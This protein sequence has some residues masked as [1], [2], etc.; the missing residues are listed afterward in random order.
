MDTR[1]GQLYPDKDAAM[2]AGVP[3]EFVR[4]VS[5]VTIASGPFAGRKY[6]Q[7]ADGSLGRRVFDN[8]KEKRP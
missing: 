5:V 4:E 7:K 2:D 1:S 6:E 8:A 3:A